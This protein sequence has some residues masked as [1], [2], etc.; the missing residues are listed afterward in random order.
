M[1]QY[2]GASSDGASMTVVLGWMCGKGGFAVQE[3]LHKFGFWEVCLVV[4]YALRQ[5]H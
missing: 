4:V 2:P 3:G 1:A 5:D